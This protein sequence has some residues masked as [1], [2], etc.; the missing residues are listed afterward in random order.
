MD[1]MKL[2]MKK[3]AAVERFGVFLCQQVRFTFFFF[4]HK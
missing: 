1:E 2:L 3:P 4:Y